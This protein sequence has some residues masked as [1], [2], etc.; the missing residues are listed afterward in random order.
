MAA[1]QSRHIGAVHMGHWSTGWPTCNGCWLMGTPSMPAHSM[2]LPGLSAVRPSARECDGL[3][4][5]WACIMRRVAHRS[6]MGLGPGW[7]TRWAMLQR[8]RSGG[9]EARR[10]QAMQEPC[11]G[12]GLVDAG[13][14]EGDGDGHRACPVDLG[15][16]SLF[17]RPSCEKSQPECRE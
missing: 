3:C 6:Q 8:R 12:S 17:I 5:R 15:M 4:A 2:V 13:L 9:W 1:R 10:L 11:I 7:E 14:A 16:P